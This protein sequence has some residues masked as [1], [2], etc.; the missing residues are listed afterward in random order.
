MDPQGIVPVFPLPGAVLYPGTV[1][2]LHVFEPRYRAMV[3]DVTRGDRLLAIA[4]LRP[5][6]DDDTAGSPP[7]HDVATIGRIEDLE[8]LPDGRSTLNLVGLQRVELREI[9][10][11]RPY[12]LVR[13]AVRPERAPDADD[14]V[15][16]RARL[17]L[18]AAH[19]MLMRELSDETIRVAVDSGLP[20]ATV[21]NGAC[22]NLPVD[23]EIR[24]TL[25]EL[26]DLRERERLASGHL[27]AVLE[28]V[29]ALK[30]E[31]GDLDGLAN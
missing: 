27:Q 29:L 20:Y 3:A 30:S 26:D 21:V 16:E 12:R 19:D 15:I 4:L 2:P 31:T 9:P 14:P 25:L 8:T 10:S 5:G 22:A 13:Y 17:E 24:Q 6:H 1:L 11:E 28:R 7:I 23:A 18:F